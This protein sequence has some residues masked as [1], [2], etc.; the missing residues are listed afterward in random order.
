MAQSLFSTTE[1]GNGQISAELHHPPALFYALVH[2]DVPAAADLRIENHTGADLGPVEVSVQLA[3]PDGPL[4]EVWSRRTRTLPASG[5]LWWDD[6]RDLVPDAAALRAA[7]EAFPVTYR[8]TVRAEGATELA[9]S[10]PSRAL[11][12]NEWLNSPS[13][14]ESIAAFVQPNADSVGHILRVAADLLERDTGS[15]SMQGYQADP[16]RVTHIGA[17][18]YEALRS[19]AITYVSLPASFEETGQKVRTTASVLRDRLGNCIDLAVTYAACLE[20]AGLHPLIWFVEGHAFAGFFL[21]DDRLPE[22][23]ALEA[24]QLVNIVESGT[25]MPVEL[26]GIGPG[27]GTL[28]FTQAVESAIGHVRGGTELLGMVDVHLA[29]KSG[30]RAMPSSDTATPDVTIKSSTPPPPRSITEL[31]AELVRAGVFEE[32]ENLEIRATDDGAPPRIHAWRRALLDLSL[33]NPLLK[34]PRTGKGLDLHVPGGALAELDDLIHD[35]KAI[36]IVAQ[37]LVSG[38]HR[39]KG[40]HRAQE[41]DPS[42]VA[43]ELRTDKRIYGAVTEAGYVSKMRAL[44]RDARTLEQ[45]T[46]SNYLYLTL[47][48][49]V[50]ATPSGE[51]RAPLFLV[52][53][54]I[55][56]GT[57]RKPYTIVVDGDETAAPNWCLIQWLKVKHNVRIPELEHP[58]TDESG[59]DINRSL[60]AIRKTLVENNLDHRID[61][62]ASLRL[63]QFSTF[64]MWRD[65]T[66]YWQTILAN[67]VVE[68][69]VNR[70]GEPFMD[71][72][73]TDDP[74]VDETELQLPIPADGSQMRA[75]AM[76]EQGRSFVLE[77]PPGTGKSQTITNLIAHAIRTGKTILF[78]AEKQAALDVVKRR[79]G[80]VGLEHFCLD[81]HGRKQ[82]VRSIRQQLKD[83]HEQ[84]ARADDH[85]W[86]VLEARYRAEITTLRGYPDQLHNPNAA[87]YSFWSAYQ[88]RLAHDAGVTAPVPASFF[89]LPE[90]VRATATHAAAELPTTAKSAQLRPEH[91][92]SLSTRRDMRG[93]DTEAVTQVAEQLE[94]A[95]AAFVQFPPALRT[96]IEGLPNPTALGAALAC[97]HLAGSGRLPGESEVSSARRP[98]WDANA[99]ALGTA[100]DE[101]RAAHKPALDTFRP[102]TF[103][104]P[105]F[106]DWSAAAVASSKGLFG[107]KKRRAALAKRIR[108]CALPGTT[109]DESTVLEHVAGLVA[110]RQAAGML[111]AQIKTLPPFGLGAG[112]LPTQPDAR[113][114]W[115]AAVQAVMTSRELSASH[116]EVWR[117]LLT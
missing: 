53:V 103:V 32:D 23:V 87:G 61:E 73:G 99:V 47:G 51:G 113:Q 48:A 90:D 95:R 76:A 105:E 86:R 34:L 9:Y 112:W 96:A 56:G 33:R 63:L 117:A 108:P 82:S 16:K 46:G 62:S 24:N 79:L 100:I 116:P 104:H 84:H 66:Q 114:Q 30:I 58:I 27:S 78:V 22:S 93:L 74:R 35:N 1:R 4:S 101:F 72:A 12:H 69:L 39:L 52:P 54:R 43:D 94:S 55:E 71:P 80:K 91:P 81:L 31:P 8:V 45:E 70:P 57:G 50:H 98:G 102:E 3:G 10:A 18:I 5:A 26:T 25:A 38:V 14:Y 115:N 75:I 88:T 41:L 20:A 89:S 2:N 106:E 37:D 49:L 59:I 15:G 17:A 65:L 67:P 77:G 64:Q 83:A 68:H 60:T 40:I 36:R 19:E 85:G 42:A 7:D 21:H 109:V 11:A 6:F 111:N 97:A 110:A 107:K 44:Q 28:T 29:H 13:V 92:W